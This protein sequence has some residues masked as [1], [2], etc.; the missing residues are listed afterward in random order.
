MQSLVV[1]ECIFKNILFYLSF[2]SKQ[3]QENAENAAGKCGKCRATKTM[4]FNIILKIADTV[5]LSVFLWRY[6]KTTTSF[7]T[8]A[9]AS[10]VFY[11]PF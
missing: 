4:L 9:P 2:R 7:M 11:I 5:W 10:S 6:C 8:L 3:N 1:P